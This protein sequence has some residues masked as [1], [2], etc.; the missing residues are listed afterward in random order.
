MALTRR[1]MWFFL[2]ILGIALC[3]EDLVL[4]AYGILSF[5]I[6]V[7]IILVYVVAINI[8]RVMARP[9]SVS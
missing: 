1:Q 2:L 7:A 8:A 5:P 6:V 9:S 4:Y 3:V